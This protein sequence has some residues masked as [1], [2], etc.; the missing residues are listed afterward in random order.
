MRNCTLTVFECSTCKLYDMEWTLSINLRDIDTH[1]YI[2]VCIFVLCVLGL[3]TVSLA[4]S[5]CLCSSFF[6]DA[7]TEPRNLKL[8]LGLQL[9]PEKPIKT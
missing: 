4:F 5:L 8:S 6:C 3:R 9:V 7:F 1:Y 2:V